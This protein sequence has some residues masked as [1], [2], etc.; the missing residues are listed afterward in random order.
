MI[1]TPT[2]KS[3][4]KKR[5]FRKS[6]STTK[7]IP[8]KNKTSTSTNST[9]TP[10]T[11][12]TSHSTTTTT[13]TTTIEIFEFFKLRQNVY[14]CKD[15]NGNWSEFKRSELNVDEKFIRQA[16]E[17]NKNVIIEPLVKI[18]FGHYD[19]KT[20]VFGGSN[21]E[22]VGEKLYAK[23]ISDGHMFEETSLIQLKR[24]V[25]DDDLDKWLNVV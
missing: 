12:R 1:L 13:T 21:L 19:G 10:I 2:E 5:K 25:P 3:S 9:S 4:Q 23:W 11:S 22:K 15:A 14:N 24:R 6:T 8:K 20:F 17:T 18:R 7:I 16:D